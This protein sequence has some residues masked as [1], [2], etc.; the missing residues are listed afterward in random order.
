MRPSTFSRGCLRAD[1]SLPAHDAAFFEQ[2][3]NLLANELS[4]RIPERAC[5]SAVLS[6]PSHSGPNLR[7]G[8]C[9]RVAHGSAPARP[10]DPPRRQ[11]TLARQ[12]A[13]SD[14]AHPERDRPR[15]PAITYHDGVPIFPDTPDGRAARLAYYEAR[16]L[17]N[18][19]NSLLDYN[20][21][22]AAASHLPSAAPANEHTTDFSDRA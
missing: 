9:T 1:G 5:T 6:H 2:A 20:D 11:Q 4:D 3:C 15:A 21:A 14:P 12:T 16:K 19:P 8:V 22:N 13:A 7:R 10:P 18:P 17:N